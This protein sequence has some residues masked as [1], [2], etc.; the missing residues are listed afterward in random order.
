MARVG[1]RFE[2][3]SPPVAVHVRTTP[4]LEEEGLE[5]SK[6][7]IEESV[8][9]HLPAEAAALDDGLPC[10]SRHAIASGMQTRLGAV[11]EQSRGSTSRFT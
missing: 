9:A 7:S 11:S 10:P 6:L 1:V 2:C 5:S 4:N 8:W 3:G